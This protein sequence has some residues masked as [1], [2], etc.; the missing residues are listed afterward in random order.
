MS[1]K[2]KSAL[3]AAG[4]TGALAILSQNALAESHK[5]EKHM[6]ET[7]QMGD[8]HQDGKDSDERG[9]RGMER[10][11][12]RIEAELKLNAQQKTAWDALKA[13]LKPNRMD[14]KKDREHHKAALKEMRTPERL[15]WM[16]AMFQARLNEMKQRNEAIKGF[17]AG[18]NDEQKA[19]FDEKFFWSKGGGHGH[20]SNKKDH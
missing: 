15:D 11:L 6:G 7:S 13:T 18:L 4:L 1:H 12:D 16:Q 10:K 20:H 5:H 9:H 2:L 17:Y 14:R 8:H 19:T 3:L